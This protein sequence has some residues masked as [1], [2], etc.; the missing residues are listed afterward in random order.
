[1]ATVNQVYELLNT[2]QQMA[3]GE[4]AVNVV[5]TSSFVALGNKVLSSS[6][7]KDLFVNTLF[8]RI[9][10]VLID[11]RT[12]SADD[13]NVIRREYEYGV[14][15]QKIHIEPRE[16][17][18]QP[19]WLIGQNDFVPEYAPVIKPIV[20][21][22]IFDD[23]VTFET[24][25]TVPD[26]MTK[27]AFVNEISFGAFTVAIM[28]ALDVGMELAKERSV[29]L[30]RATMGA[31]ILANN[32]ANAIDLL[33]RY[34]D[35]LP[36]GSTPLTAEQ[37]LKTP[38]ALSD[39]AMIMSLTADRMTRANKIFNNEEYTRFTPKDLLRVDVLNVLDYA[40]KFGLRPVVYNENFIKLPNYKTVPYWLG[41]DED[42]N[43]EGISKI[44]ISKDDGQGGTETVANQS[45]VLSMMY[46]TEACGVNIFAEESAF[47]RNDH[48]HYTT[49]Y[50][51]MTAQYYVDTSEQ[52]TIFYLGESN[53][54]TGRQAKAKAT[55]K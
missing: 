24:G 16:A 20:K 17:Q 14:A 51:Q 5:D 21:Q 23:M 49:Y 47:D 27:T 13:N 39:C 22:K 41:A 15:M 28:N 7:N 6:T 29:D 38:E 34:N 53:Q 52:C 2:V 42:Y 50:R 54:N 45:G 10:L 37:Y 55:T 46:D 35:S 4:I 31:Y 40:I 12:Y 9:G 8:D 18:P 3:Y 19:E 26:N 43:F 48:A 11:T 44:A 25:A 32:G 33:E 1:M 36:S 30:T